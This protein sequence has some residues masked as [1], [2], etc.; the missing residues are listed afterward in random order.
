MKE[1]TR[2]TRE[3]RQACIDCPLAL[4]SGEGGQR[5]AVTAGGKSPLA[6]PYTIYCTG[7]GRRSRKVAHLAVYTGL[8][9]KW[10]PRLE[11]NGGR[12]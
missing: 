2:I 10:C 3:D 12:S 6:Q 9:P 11:E 8:V 5:L 7:T 4:H 1:A